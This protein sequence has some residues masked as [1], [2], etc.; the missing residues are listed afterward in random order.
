M[1]E[2]RASRAVRTIHPASE[3]MAV[4]TPPALLA[5]GVDFP[6]VEAPATPPEPPSDSE[7]RRQRLRWEFTVRVSVSALILVFNEL[8]AH[9]QLTSSIIRLTALIAL[10]MNAPYYVAIRS[11]VRLRAQSYVRMLVDV[12]LM[13][14]GLYGAGGLGAAQYLAIY[15]IVP[16]Y[17]AFVFSSRACVVGTGFATLSYLAVAVLQTLGVLPYTHFPLPDAWTIAAFNLLV[18]NIVGWVA[19]LIAEAYRVSRHRLAALYVE[20]ERAHDESLTLNAEIQSASRRYVLSEVVAGVTHVVR[21]ALQGAFGHLWLARRTGQPLSAEVKG[22][23]DQVE[24]ACDSAM[25]IIRTTLDMAR[26]PTPKREPVDVGDVVRRIV[27]LKSFDL[28]RDGI[29]LQTEMADGLPRVLA[30]PYQLQQVLLNLVVNAHEELRGSSGRRQID[31]V[32]STAR[33]RVIVDVRDSGGGLPLTV[34]PHVFEPF[35][36]TKEHGNGLGLAI[37]AG[38]VEA[39]GGTL[40]ADNRREGGAVFRITLPAVG[41]TPA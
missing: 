16:V 12:A 28:R 32:A 31:V 37:A 15:A 30:S 10:V 38:I 9:E 8:L 39:F 6:T 34:V 19:V 1:S 4:P 25:R 36:T 26:R 41:A 24:A 22:H 29:T 23:L 35:Y 7:R 33:D 21:D 5:G 2:P 20:L 13:T 17:T 11:G 40:A 27:E 14:A 18:V 3:P